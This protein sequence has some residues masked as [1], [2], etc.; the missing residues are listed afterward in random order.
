MWA[1]ANT[2]TRMVPEFMQRAVPCVTPLPR[3]SIQ[4]GASPLCPLLTI[5]CALGVILLLG[6]RLLLH[7]SLQ[8]GCRILPRPEALACGTG[9]QPAAQIVWL[10]SNERQQW[11][12][13]VQ[14]AA[15]RARPPALAASPPGRLLWRSSHP[16]RLQAGCP[17]VPWAPAATARRH[18][19]ARSAALTAGGDKH[20]PLA[21]LIHGAASGG[22]PLQIGC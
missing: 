1:P 10:V 12:A 21:R 5:G 22:P 16:L 7:S 17:L 11:L 19:A 13:A 4:R 6:R 2:H 3:W 18:A 15:Q 9:V 8:E 20:L 14:A